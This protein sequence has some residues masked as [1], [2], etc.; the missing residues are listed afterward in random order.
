[1]AILIRVP[2][3][4]V[5]CGI[6]P[7]KESSMSSKKFRFISSAALVVLGLV[8]VIV[9]FARHTQ[10]RA[11]AAEKPQSATQN[12]PASAS[13]SAPAAQELPQG[14]ITY[15]AKALTTAQFLARGHL[16]ESQYMTVAE[17]VD[18][19]AKANDGKTSFKKGDTVLIPGIE[20]QPVVE[21]TRPFPKD[22]EVRAIY[23]TGG[24]AGS[25]HGIELVKRW[26]AAGGNAVVFDIKDSDGSIN[27]PFEHPLAK[28][29]QHHP[30]TNLP[31]YVRFLHSLD[32][33][34]IARQALFRD[35]NIA[36][37][38]SELAVQ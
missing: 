29:V 15:T 23:M 5:R 27:V 33:H 34:V 25:A 9:L 8:V 28:K 20:P 37:N 31:K 38:H 22:E 11:V 6:D 10:I 18:A 14:T 19:I 7:G 36:Q 12:P 4:M 30:I 35:D 17:Y 1:P 2:A 13:G 24:T 3:R 26:K 21:K 16:T 32:M